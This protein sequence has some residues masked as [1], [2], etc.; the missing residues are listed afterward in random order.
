MSKY[1]LVFNLRHSE[2]DTKD[3]KLILSSLDND[4]CFDNDFSRLG[5]YLS[6]LFFTEGAEV[7]RTRLAVQPTVFTILSLL[8]VTSDSPL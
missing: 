6:L 2:E 4:F 1:C 8:R 3:S 5:V 7:T